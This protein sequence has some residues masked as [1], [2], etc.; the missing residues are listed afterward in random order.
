M[1][2]NRN[3]IVELA[4]SLLRQLGRLPAGSL[5]GVDVLAGD[6]SQRQFLRLNFENDHSIIA[7]CPSPGQNQGKEEARSAWLIGSHLYRADVPVPEPIAYDQASSLILFEDLGDTRLHDVA[8]REGV[9]PGTPCFSL[10][11]A[12]VRELAHMQVAAMEGFDVTWCWQTPYYDRQ[13][14]LEREAGYFNQAL[15]R[16]FFGLEPDVDALYREFSLIADNAASAP[17]S[18]FLH[19]DFQSRNIMVRD[20]RV[21]IIDFQGGRLGPLGYDL[22]SLLI[23]PYVNLSSPV[24]EALLAEYI[25][26]LRQKVAYEPD[27]FHAEYLYLAL[28][29]NMQILGAFAFLGR[30]KGKIFFL[31]FIKPALYSLHALL[32][33]V[34]KKSY[35]VLAGIISACLEKTEQD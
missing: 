6:G 5:A 21:R 16:D 30:Q 22:A 27:R 2:E 29:R 14:M 18:Y 19:R 10:Y 4:C 9:G 32:L 3:Q 17:A 1:Q 24:Q 31:R 34:D 26:L 12:V 11:S 25:D 28:Q 8:L 13:L 7:V 23:D 35:P 15:C 20:G 33:Q